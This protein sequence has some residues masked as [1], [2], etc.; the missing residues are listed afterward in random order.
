MRPFAARLVAPASPRPVTARSRAAAR[1]AFSPAPRARWLG[2]RGG[3]RRCGGRWRRRGGHCGDRERLHRRLTSQRK[4]GRVRLEAQEDFRIVRRDPGTVRDEIVQRAGLLHGLE[5]LIRA[6]CRCRSGL[7]RGG[8][9]WHAPRRRGRR[10]GLRRLGGFRPGGVHRRLA[11]RRQ[12]GVVADEAF[13]R[14]L[15][16][17]LNARAMG[18]EIG[19]AGVANSVALGLRGLLRRRV[20]ERQG[21]KQGL[22]AAKIRACKTSP[23]CRGSPPR[24]HGTP[25]RVQQGRLMPGHVLAM[26]PCDAP[27]IC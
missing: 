9:G 1:R 10:R 14:F 18:D 20:I 12:L 6:S 16:A 11:R 2:G 13:E 23:S 22:P 15:A 4:I 17:G 3:W 8:R 26:R 24:M 25:A 27:S 7:G 19:A 21:D 5:L